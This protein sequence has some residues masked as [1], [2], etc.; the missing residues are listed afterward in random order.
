MTRIESQPVESFYLE[1]K[2]GLFFVVKGLLHPPGRIL[3]VLRY[4]P[5]PQGDRII[6]GRHYQRLYHFSEQFQFLEACYPQYLAY[7]QASELVQQSVPVA[8]I[9]HVYDPRTWLKTISATPS[10]NALQED[11]LAFCDLLAHAA[12]VPRDHLGVSGSLLIGLHTSHSDL[13]ITVHGECSCRAVHKTL[14]A[15]LNASAVN[16]LSRF[17]RQGLLHLYA[18]RLPDTRMDFDQFIALERRKSFQG[19]FR[20]RIF[21]VRFVKEPNEIGESYGDH[22]Y[23]PLHQ[24]G[25]AATVVSEA[26]AIFTPCSYPL[27]DVQFLQ[28]DPVDSLCETV[29]YRGRFCEQARPG[30][31]VYA[32]GTV[33]RVQTREGRTW[34]RLILGNRSEDHMTRWR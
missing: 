22:H 11:A 33:E 34:H 29:S 13:D 18:E 20:G 19:L 17:D 9:E 12:G 4:V 8:S 7:D 30:E 32:F 26:G 2:E 3:S 28:G 31:R 25:I 5:H 10:R 24:A 6:G 23:K 14:Q 1:T 15:L 27:D 16:G 21:F